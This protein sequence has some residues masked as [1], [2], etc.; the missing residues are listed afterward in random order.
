MQTQAGNIE[1]EKSKERILKSATN[2]FAQK[3]YDA[4]GIRE[5][6]KIAKANICMI[7]YFWGGKKGLY[8]GILNDLVEKQLKFAA[9]F[10]DVKKDPKELSKKEQIKLLYAIVNKAIDFLYGD[11]LS[12]DL[13][14]FLIKEQHEPKT[15][16]KSPFISYLRKLVGAIFEKNSDDKEIIYKTLF[17]VSQ[18]NSARLMPAFSLKLL[19]QKKFKEDDIKIIKNNLKSYIDILIKEVQG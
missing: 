17:I 18:I 8:R 14:Y 6:C 5:I 3:G 15:N 11:S 4:V 2:L 19:K 9:R 1:K 13:F 7:S 16:I 12:P 10:I